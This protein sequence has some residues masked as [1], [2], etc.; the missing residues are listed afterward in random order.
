MTYVVSTF[1]AF[2]DLPDY[3]EKAA[4]IRE[5]AQTTGMRGSILVA[6]EGVN[7]TMAGTREEIDELF[8]FLRSDERF[9]ALSSKESFTDVLPFK[10]MKVRLKKEIV[11]LGVPEANPARQVGHYVKAADWNA[12]ISDPDVI[13][14]DV[15]NRYEVELGTF[16]RA[17]NPDIASFRQFPDFVQTQLSGQKHKKIATFCTGGIRCEKA[18]ALLMKEGFHEVYH[19]EGGILKYLESVP[20]AKSLWNGTCFVFDERVAL[21]HEL[22]PAGE[23]ADRQS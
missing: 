18:T 1:Y 16:K 22:H 23:E 7:A 21:D 3:V 17:V 5:H 2:I 9:A 12:L 20:E 15:R 8:A 4:Q 14:V 6:S 11:T 19:L 13:V 10:R